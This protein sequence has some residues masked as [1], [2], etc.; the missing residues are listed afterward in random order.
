M[1]L[2]ATPNPEAAGDNTEYMGLS[3][4]CCF[5]YLLTDKDRVLGGL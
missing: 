5:K 4:R 2:N 3:R 1:P